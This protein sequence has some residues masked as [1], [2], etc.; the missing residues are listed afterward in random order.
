MMNAVTDKNLTSPF[1]PKPIKTAIIEDQKKIRE[2]LTSLIEFTPGFICAGSYRSM[3]EALAQIS[4]DFPDV[5]LSDIGLPG[6]DGIEGIKILKHKYP[7]LTVLMLTVYDDDE[8][9]FDAICAGASGYLLK[10][11]APTKLLENIRD[12]VEGGSPMSPTVASRVLKLFREIRPPERANYDLTP[13]ELRLLKCLVDGHNYA[14]AAKANNTSINTVKF[15][16]KQIYE[17]LQVHSKSEAVA[18]ALRE[19]IIN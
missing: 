5:V 4:F 8:R 16:I 9:I 7:H 6:M 19:R 1:E 2:G 15:Y 12:A 11:T 14:T 3:E 18:K 17:K 13:H 10:S